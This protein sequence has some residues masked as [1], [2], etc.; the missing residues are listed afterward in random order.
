MKVRDV[1]KL[2]K[3]DGWYRIKSRSGH[4]Q[5]KHL[6]KPGRLTVSGGL[7]DELPPG[8]LK[9]VFRQAGWKE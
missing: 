1:L 9:S 2:L 6:T 8:T 4:R 5:F 3:K 7:G